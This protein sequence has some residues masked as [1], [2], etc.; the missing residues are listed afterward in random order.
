MKIDSSN[1]QKENKSKGKQQID[2]E[3][4]QKLIKEIV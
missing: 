2:E 4:N 1:F 3:F